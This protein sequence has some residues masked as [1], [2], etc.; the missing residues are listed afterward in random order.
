MD[1]ELFPPPLERYNADGIRCR[2]KRT[3]NSR[4]LCA[5]SARRGRSWTSR[6]GMAD[7]HATRVQPGAGYGPHHVYN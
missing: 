3:P 6:V 2:R 1:H 4:Q 5:S 7:D